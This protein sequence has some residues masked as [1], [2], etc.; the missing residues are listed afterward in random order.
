MLREKQFLLTIS[1][2]STSVP[3][4][5]IYAKWLALKA[6]FGGILEVIYLAGITIINSKSTNKWLQKKEVF[7]DF[8]PRVSVSDEKCLNME[9]VSGCENLNTV[10]KVNMIFNKREKQ[11]M[12]EKKSKDEI[13][14][15]WLM[16]RESEVII[17]Q[18]L[19]IVF[20]KVKRRIMRLLLWFI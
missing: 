15:N 11:Y 5:F 1:R 2:N 8:L 19:F 4:D 13:K 20:M 16:D 12:K 9:N 6:T 3:L 14:R 18:I 10:Y 17:S 7:Q